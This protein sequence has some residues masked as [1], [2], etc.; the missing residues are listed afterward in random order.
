M[1]DVSYYATFLSLVNFLSKEIF[2]STRGNEEKKNPNLFAGKSS[3]FK[4]YT[5]SLSDLLIWGII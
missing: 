5:W 4:V 2:F 1:Q 3:V